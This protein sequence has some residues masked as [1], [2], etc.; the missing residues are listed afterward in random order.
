MVEY[1]LKLEIESYKGVCCLI[2]IEL[3]RSMN[4]HDIWL[5]KITF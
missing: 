4:E 1:L 3:E 5:A 2:P